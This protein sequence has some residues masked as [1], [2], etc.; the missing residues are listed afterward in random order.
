MSSN[1]NDV[2]EGFKMTELGPL[3]E[4]WDVTSL[5]DVFK[6]VDL[7]AAKFQGQNADKLPVLSLTKNYG[8][9]LQSERFGKRIALEDISDYKVVK[10]GEIVYNPYVIWEGAIHILDRFDYGLVSPVYPVLKTNLERAVPYFLDQLL[11]TPLAVSAYNRFAAGAVNRRR[12][13]RKTDFMAIR[14][15][16]PPLPE[17]KAIARVLSIIQ[18]AIEAQEKIIAAAMELKKSLLRH[19]FT[20]GPVPVSE[21][22]RVTL[23]ETEIGQVPEHWEQKK[24]GEIVTIIYGVQAAVAHLTDSSI[25]MVLLCF[26]CRSLP[27]LSIPTVP[28]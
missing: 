21:A 15:P 17:Q 10:H 2:P 22:E 11:R 14:I 3:P 19:L 13:I 9:M 28:S 12:S 5:G 20:Y 1:N 24:L 25:G 7:R 6:E 26:S 8:L 27:A 4:K 16:L 18:K 23:T